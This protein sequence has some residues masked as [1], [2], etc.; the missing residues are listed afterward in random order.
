MSQEQWPFL[1]GT[2]LNKSIASVLF[3]TLAFFTPLAV[4]AQPVDEVTQYVHA[5][6]ARQKIPGLAL[7]VAR[8]G[9]PVRME[10]YGLAD[11]ELNV[12]VTPDTLF[13]SGSV[14]K[15]F[16]ASGVML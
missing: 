7:L 1:R 4:L 5:E 13:Q 3:S 11:V 2:V 6:M 10:G 12:P 14:G 8:Y 16:T 9:K 15:Q